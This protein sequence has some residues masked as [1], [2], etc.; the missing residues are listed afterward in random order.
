MGVVLGRARPYLPARR[1]IA[2]NSGL[3]SILSRILC[4]QESVNLP[5]YLNPYCSPVSPQGG[6]SGHVTGS[7]EWMQTAGGGGDLRGSG[8][9]QVTQW[10]A[11]SMIT[12]STP[13]V[14]RVLAAEVDLVFTH[15]SGRRMQ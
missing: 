11:L 5:G 6:C 1:G 10:I 14:I 3:H 9:S 2:R 4:I 7:S 15:T 12:M 13:I 8:G